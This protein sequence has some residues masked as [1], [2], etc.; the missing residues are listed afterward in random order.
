MFTQQAINLK[1]KVDVD[2]YNKGCRIYGGFSIILPIKKICGM[3]VSVSLKFHTNYIN[4]VILSDKIDNRDYEGNIHEQS[5]YCST[6]LIRFIE[7]P[8][9][10]DYETAL[11]NLNELLKKLKFNKYYGMFETEET[12]D[13][14]DFWNVILGDNPHIELSYGMCCICHDITKST[15]Y[16]CCNKPLCY[17]CWDKLTECR[18]DECEEQPECDCEKTNC[19]HLKC[20]LCRCSLSNGDSMNF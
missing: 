6:D 17:E 2:F 8:S 9:L 15:S 18:C 20:P 7:K 5:L 19:G 11:L 16:N 3:E 14:F 1:N 4:L 12:Y 10:E 13:T